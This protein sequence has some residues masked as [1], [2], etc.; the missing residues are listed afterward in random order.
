MTIRVL[1]V[2]DSPL[3]R[4][5]LQAIVNEQPDMQVVGMAADAYAARDMVRD[6]HPDVITLDVEMPKV[7]GLTFLQ[8]L[9]QVRP[10]PV[11]MVSSHTD[12]GSDITF[13]AL[14]SGAVDF[15]TKPAGAA[16]GQDYGQLIA[17]R[18]RA[19]APR[20][21]ATP[22]RKA[23]KRAP[24][25]TPHVIFIGASTGGTQAI[26]EILQAMPASSPP[27]LIVQHMPENFSQAFARRL[28]GLCEIT[29][30]EAEDEEPVLP[31]HAYIAPAG[32]HLLVRKPTSPGRY[33][34]QL[35]ADADPV[36][37]HRP[38]IDILFRSAAKR[39]A[40]GATGVLLTG[41]GKDGATGLLEM[42]QAGASTIAQDE[43][44]SVVFGMPREAIKLGA[45]GDVLPL[46]SIGPRLRAL[47]KV[48][49]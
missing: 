26:Q 29:V 27:V 1:I 4:S 14:E 33:T 43:A 17:Y 41:M 12:A 9:M 2:D 22:P 36:N 3:I 32:R 39:V 11:I 8:Q 20:P 40:P 42:K 47:A 48:S 45:A 19:A 18:I 21:V 30:K 15:V 31:G 25:D 37:L 6:L 5:V 49:S 35:A 24:A 44:T 46:G 7:D 10:T 16:C 13:R 34:L 23:G 28:D 38:S